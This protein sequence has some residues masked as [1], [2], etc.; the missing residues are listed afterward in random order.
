[1]RVDENDVVAKRV[2]D[3]KIDPNAGRTFIMN[4]QWAASRE[5]PRA[6][7][8]RLDT[9]LANPDGTP[10]QQIDATAAVRAI[11][12]ALPELLAGKVIDAEALPALPAPAEPEGGQ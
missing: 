1:M 11:V 7:G 9:R 2:L 5:A 8:D 12:D 6:Y 10:L 4:N 3:G